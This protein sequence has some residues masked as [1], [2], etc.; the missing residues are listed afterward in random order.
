MA[1][2]C[3]SFFNSLL[4]VDPTVL[5]NISR[6]AEWPFVN[7]I[8]AALTRVVYHALWLTMMFLPPISLATM[9]IKYSARLLVLFPISRRALL[10]SLSKAEYTWLRRM[11]QGVSSGLTCRTFPENEQRVGQNLWS[12]RKKN[13][14]E[15]PSAHWWD[16]L[17]Y[18]SLTLL[19]QIKPP[20]FMY[21][22]KQAKNC[23][24]TTNQKSQVFKNFTKSFGHD[25]KCPLNR[26]VSIYQIPRKIT[27]R[28]PRNIKSHLTP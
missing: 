13:A 25:G 20:N 5:R 19:C 12:P 3:A 26:P 8:P 9:L 21:V 7:R 6:R 28:I 17:R 15:L 22:C 24:E 10:V 27:N 14:E 4:G 18:S 11:L 2:R 23:P 16:H 1:R